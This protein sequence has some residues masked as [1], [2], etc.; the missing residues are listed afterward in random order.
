MKT[1]EQAVLNLIG[2]IGLVV[3]N[4]FLL[5][6]FL[7]TTGE[8]WGIELFA[9]LSWEQYW[10]FSGILGFY[11][12]SVSVRNQILENR[13]DKITEKGPYHGVYTQFIYTIG[14][15]IMLGLTWGVNAIFF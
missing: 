4:V 9:N 5:K 12:L 1:T 14:G 8:I 2:T 11:I 10:A 6:W 15:F 3:L 7:N 13:V